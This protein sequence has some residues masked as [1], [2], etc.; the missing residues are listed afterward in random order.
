MTSGCHE[1]RTIDRRS[2]V[3][4][5]VDARRDSARRA[6]TSPAAEAAPPEAGPEIIDCNVHLFHWPFRKLKYD[7]TEALVA[8]LRKHRITQ[9]WAGSFEAV[10]HK[11]LDLMNRRLAEECRMHG[12]GTLLPIG[13]V[14]PAG[15]DWEEDLRRCHEQYRMPRSAAVPGLSRVHARSPRVRALARRRR[16]S[17]ACW[18]RSSCGWK[19]SACIILAIDVG[20]VSVTPLPDALK[21]VPEAKVQLINSAGPLLGHERRGPGAGDASHLRYCRHR[22]QRRRRTS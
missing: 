2:F 4:G 21:K 11:Q 10:L 3:E 22:R 5:V 19:T 16:R 8:K 13:S 1:A 15:P 9:A 20:S 17:A 6:L 12:D 14:N 7:R 18:C